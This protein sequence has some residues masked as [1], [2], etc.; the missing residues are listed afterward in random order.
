MEDKLDEANMGIVITDEQIIAAELTK[1]L[2]D[3]FVER[4]YVW[5]GNKIEI[6][7]KIVK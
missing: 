7:W 2:I 4:I 1:E 3:M 5:P 6:V